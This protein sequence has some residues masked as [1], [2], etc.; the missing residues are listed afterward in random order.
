MIKAEEKPNYPRTRLESSR[1]KTSSLIPLTSLPP[2]P[3]DLQSILH[4]SLQTAHQA[5]RPIIEV[6]RMITKVS[7]SRSHD[8]AHGRAVTM[9]APDEILMSDFGQQLN[10]RLLLMKSGSI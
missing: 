2:V 4:I 7:D 3:I 1:S 9:L 6:E 10:N 5:T 8:S